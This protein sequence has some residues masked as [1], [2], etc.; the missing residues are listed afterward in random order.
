MMMKEIMIYK[1]KM[2]LDCE[3]NAKR[4]ANFTFENLKSD[5]DSRP[6][7]Q[8]VILKISFYQRIC[9]LALVQSISIYLKNLVIF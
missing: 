1:E 4:R 8:F 2:T 5:L 3:K 6:W 9:P 7:Y